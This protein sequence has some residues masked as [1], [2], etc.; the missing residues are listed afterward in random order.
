MS[1]HFF[2]EGFTLIGRPPTGRTRAPAEA[3]REAFDRE[4]PRAIEDKSGGRL[5]A[6]DVD[7]SQCGLG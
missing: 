2:K 6:G 5:I 1:R 7:A 4:L 3:L